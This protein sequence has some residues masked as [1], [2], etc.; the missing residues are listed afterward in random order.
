LAQAGV[1]NEIAVTMERSSPAERLDLFSRACGLTSAREAE[2]FGHLAT[3]A[4]TRRIAESMFLSELKVQDHLKAIFAKTGAPKRSVLLARA[5][6]LN[7][8]H[9][10]RRTRP[11]RPLHER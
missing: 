3:G 8:T 2:L 7:P 1:G 6:A 9:L 11:R 4:H 5:T 10:S